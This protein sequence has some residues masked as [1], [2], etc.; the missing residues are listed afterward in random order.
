MCSND[1]NCSTRITDDKFI[2]HFINTNTLLCI[3][4]KIKG[5]I[6][7][8]FKNFK[9]RNDISKYT[10]IK[11]SSLFLLIR[12]NFTCKVKLSSMLIKGEF[13]EI[14]FYVNSDID[15]VNY[16]NKKEVES[17]KI[18]VSDNDYRGSS[19]EGENSRGGSDNKG[20]MEEG[21]EEVDNN[22]KGNNKGKEEVDRK[23]NNIDNNKGKNI[24]INKGNTKA[25]TPSNTSGNEDVDCFGINNV[26][27]NEIV[28]RNSK[29]KDCISISLLLNGNENS[30]LYYLSF[31]GEKGNEMAKAVVTKY[32]ARSYEDITSKDKGYSI[33]E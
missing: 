8:V 29:Y 25:N 16:K 7:L 6:K 9:D 33:I 1:C 26:H 5:N 11:P 13:K 3:N 28:L 19:K 21:K 20:S 18:N 27:I 17:F 10:Q 12:I 32:E 15:S 30:K 23:G 24:N 4:E 2:N 22:Y 14:K 31:K